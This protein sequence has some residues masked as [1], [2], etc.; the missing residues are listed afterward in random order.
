MP[1]QEENTNLPEVEEMDEERL[2][3]EILAERA[4]R[5]AWQFFT[6]TNPFFVPAF[7]EWFSSIPEEFKE[8][9]LEPF[10]WSNNIICLIK[11]LSLKEDWSDYN[12]ACYDLDP[13]QD[14]KAP[15]FPIIQ[16]DTIENYPQWY[17]I[18][19]TNPPYLAK[20]SATRR[21]LDYNY[22]Q[23]EDLYQKALEVMLMYNEYVA[24]II[25]ESFINSWLFT[26]RLFSFVSLTCKMFDD[27]DCPVCLAM[28]SP[29]EK[30][31]EYFDNPDDFNVYRMDKKLWNYVSIKEKIDW[32]LNHSSE[33]VRR[34]FNNPEWNIWIRCIDGT[35]KPSIEFI[36]W[37]SID[38]NRIKVSS[39]SLTR[40]SWLPEHIDFNEFINECNRI[41]NE[42]REISDDICLT[43]FKWLRA[44]GCYRR[45]LDFDTARKIMNSA[46]NNLHTIQPSLF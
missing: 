33:T 46:C 1:G 13:S 8:T 18:A 3:A 30:K 22:P 15:E 26:N 21:W 9:L 5:E 25:P 38:P 39:R 45:R 20:N 11:E 29:I 35:K 34:D 42:Y 28:F 6:I 36:D 44:D 31:R 16:Q 14:N 4:K 40:V 27:T 2:Q 23:Y 24:A 12:W 7:Y 37:E 41:L 43:S 19:I 10:A 17:H 32:L